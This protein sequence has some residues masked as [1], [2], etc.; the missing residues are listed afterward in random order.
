MLGAFFI[1]V[2]FVSEKTSCIIIAMLH[3]FL[4]VLL[5]SIGNCSLPTVSTKNQ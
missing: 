2:S 4:F 5:R 1:Q 3:P